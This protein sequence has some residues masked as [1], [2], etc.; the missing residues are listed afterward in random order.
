ML[1]RAASEDSPGSKSEKRKG[2]KKKDEESPYQRPRPSS[3][4]TGELLNPKGKDADIDFQVKEN[5]RHC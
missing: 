4:T 1:E 5:P 2:E 3:T